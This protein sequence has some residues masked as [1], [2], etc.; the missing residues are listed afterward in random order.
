M[1]YAIL[2][3]P[4]HNRVFYEAMQKLALSE[5]DI[6]ARKL[7]VSYH[8]LQNQLISG[9]S[10]LTFETP[11]E[12]TAS[13]IT[14]LSELSFAYALYLLEHVN[15]DRYLKPIAKTNVSYIDTSISDILKYTGKTNELFTRMLINIAFATQSCPENLNLLDPVS[16]KGTT[17]FEGLIKGFNVYGVEIGEKP[18]SEAYHFFQKYLESKRY[19]FEMKSMKISGPNKSFSAVR[20]TFTIGR[21]KEEQ[22]EGNVTT[23]EF[24]AGN[25]QYVTRYYRKDFFSMIVG[26]L[27]YGIQHGNVTNEKRSSLTRNPAE[28]LKACLPAWVEVLCPGGCLVLA[29]NSH[30]LNRE[31]MTGLFEA[32][33]LSVKNEGTYTQFEHRVDQSIKRDVIAGV[34]QNNSR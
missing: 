15:S 30:V 29:W 27:P 28:L 9:I 12:L 8:N 34:K 13:D 7:S 1:R 16:G 18:V 4:G 33:G 11:S 20:H 5:F 14:L 26:D 24:I 22:K 23:A 10:Y 6:V 17:L 21:T 32:H 19:K 2:Y 31:T 25:S 3:H